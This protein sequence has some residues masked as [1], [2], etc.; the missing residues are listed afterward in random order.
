M[1][2]SCLDCQFYVSSEVNT[3][4]LKGFRI[5]RNQKLKNKCEWF[6]KPNNDIIM[7][8]PAKIKEWWE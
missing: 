1:N 4:C 3:P 6:K 2:H 7:F 8:V 5:N